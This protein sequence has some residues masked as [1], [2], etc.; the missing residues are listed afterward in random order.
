MFFPTFLIALIA[1]SSSIGIWCIFCVGGCYIVEFYKLWKKSP[2]KAKKMVDI[3]VDN[4]TL[5]GKELQNQMVSHAHAISNAVFVTDDENNGVMHPNVDYYQNMPTS[6]FANE[7]RVASV[8]MSSVDTT[9]SKQENNEMEINLNE[10]NYT[11]KK[12]NLVTPNTKQNVTAN[13]IVMTHIPENNCES[14]AFVESK[15][16]G[17]DID[18][19]TTG[20]SH[21]NQEIVGL[22]YFVKNKEFSNYVGMDYILGAGDNKISDDDLK[23]KLCEVLE[24]CNNYSPI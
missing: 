7:T 13:E 18:A 10:V 1:L 20:I 2:A 15:D 24:E 12:S 8:S 5:F 9:E 6:V 22:I 19:V 17:S 21:S 11:Y 3:T 16:M 23:T 14:N 4:W